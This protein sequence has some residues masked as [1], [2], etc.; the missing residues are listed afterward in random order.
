MKRKPKYKYN[1]SKIWPIFL[2]YYCHVCDREFRREWG[3]RVKLPNKLNVNRYVCINC[4]PNP[5]DAE[6]NLH[7]IPGSRPVPPP[8]SPEINIKG[9]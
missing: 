1:V 2:W 9:G 5:K 8:G 7:K 3:W 6:I 4:A